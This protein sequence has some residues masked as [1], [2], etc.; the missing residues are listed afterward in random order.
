MM[1]DAVLRGTRRH[2]SGG[3][4][5]K[6]CGA[7]FPNLTAPGRGQRPHVCKYCRPAVQLTPGRKPEGWTR[8]TPG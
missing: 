4:W 6:G 8:P 7:E 1:S 2:G 3:F 5:C